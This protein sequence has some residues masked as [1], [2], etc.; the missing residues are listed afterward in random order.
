MLNATAV[1]LAA[2]LGTR[3]GGV[4]PKVLL[5]AAGRPLLAYVLDTV[6]A[7]GCRRIVVVEGPAS[8]RPSDSFRAPDTTFVTQ[9][10]RLGTAH[11]LRQ[12]ED[13][14]RG[15]KD[16]VL[17]VHG[18]MPLMSAASLQALERARDRAGAYA[19][20]LATESQGVDLAG[21]GRVFVSEDFI[22]ERIVEAKDLAQHTG[23]PSRGPSLVNVGG[24]LFG[25]GQAPGL[26][27]PGP[28]FRALAEVRD[29][30]A[31]K[32]Y[33]LPDVI[34][35]LAARGLHTLAVTAADA[36]EAL[37]VNTPEELHRVEQTLLQRAAL[38][39]ETS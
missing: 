11:A 34:A 4:F 9:A 32:E 22:V 10:E 3:M 18:D 16:A 12:A 25:G 8:P 33:Y 7:A 38:R 13:T 1:I 35:L 19:A 26:R 6:R 21:L 28:L 20:L 31:Q 14:L 39:V 29:A 37:G 2:G 23:H 15:T 5:E 27:G 36:R 17:V 30:N 24:Y